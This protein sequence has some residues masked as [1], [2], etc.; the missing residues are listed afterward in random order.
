MTSKV[1]ASVGTYDYGVTPGTVAVEARALTRGF[2]AVMT[3][4]RDLVGRPSRVGKTARPYNWRL[5]G[6]F[7]LDMGEDGRPL[8]DDLPHVQVHGETGVV[9]DI[10]AL[11]WLSGDDG[12]DETL[13]EFLLAQTDASLD[14]ISSHYPRLRDPDALEELSAIADAVDQLGAPK[15][16][17]ELLAANFSPAHLLRKV[18]APL[19]SKQ[20]AAQKEK[21][22]RLDQ[23][24]AD[25]EQLCL[26]FSDVSGK[27]P[28]PSPRVRI[29]SWIRDYVS[30]NGKLPSGTHD[31]SGKP[32][33]S[34]SMGKIDF[35][36]GD[37]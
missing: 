28:W 15:D 35:G 7:I 5:F 17:L 26:Q 25:I 21:Q 22:K 27:P 4:D 19:I 32:P 11:C 6:E 1:I 14:Y 3:G 10:L 34:F 9:A 37:A 30:E 12:R 8:F 16:M 2:S 23:F 24:Q 13:M 18:A 36:N 20:R 33:H 31:V 29:R